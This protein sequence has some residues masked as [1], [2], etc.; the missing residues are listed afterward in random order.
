[1]DERESTSVDLFLFSDDRTGARL[2][3]LTAELGDRDERRYR[4]R[5]MTATIPRNM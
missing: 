4:E 2:G 5:A 3:C 1:L